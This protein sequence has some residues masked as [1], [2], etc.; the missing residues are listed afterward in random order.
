MSF[1]IGQLLRIVVLFKEHTR[2]KHEKF[3]TLSNECFFNISSLI[4]QRIIKKFEHQT[5][6]CAAT[7]ILSRLSLVSKTQN[8]SQTSIIID[9]S[10]ALQVFF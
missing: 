5:F 10:N 1:G 9:F 4:W 2:L 8:F 3:T 7:R 6:I